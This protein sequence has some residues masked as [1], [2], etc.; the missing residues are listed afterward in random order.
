M[1][2]RRNAVYVTSVCYFISVIFLILVIIGN[3]SDKV[4]I[5]DLFFFKIRLA[6]IIPVEAPNSRL[7][8]SVARSLG[9][10]D[11]YQVGLWNFCEGFDDEGIVY[12]SP[13][14]RAYWF[15][16]VEVLMDELLAG[17]KIALPGEVLTI[18]KLL[19]IGS[20]TMFGL[21]IAGIVLSFI[22]IFAPFLVFRTRRW[23]F[24]VVTVSILTAICVVG[25]TILATVFSLVAKYALTMQS[26]LN[27]SADVSP[28]M[29]ASTWIAAALTFT[30]FILHSAV[31]CCCRLPRTKDK[32]ARPVA[33]ETGA[34]PGMEEKAGTKKKFS[35]HDFINKKRSD[36][37]ASSSA[38]STSPN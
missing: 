21:F 13:P 34:S 8:N 33:S 30:A 4:G 6:H 26:E 16:P 27:I 19:R 17:A 32:K 3:T 12:C 38:V 36:H 37:A 29:L 14:K 25:G 28:L 31:G 7:L 5:R 18:L 24:L 1:S 11:F 15:N 22:M 35:V 20:Q 2:N 10:H 23:F 9:L